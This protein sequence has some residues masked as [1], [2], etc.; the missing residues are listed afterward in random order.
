M[1]KAEILTAL[2]GKLGSKAKFIGVYTLHSIITLL[3]TGVISKSPIVFILLASAEGNNM[4]HWIAVYINPT[5][6]L[7]GFFDSYNEN[8]YFYSPNLCQLLRRFSK[9]GY[10]SN[11]FQLQG[12][13]SYVCGAYVIQFVSLASKYGVKHAFQYFM[14]VFKRGHRNYNDR[15]I[16]SLAFKQFRMPQCAQTFCFDINDRDCQRTI[17]RLTG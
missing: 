5:S 9:Y 17:C 13:Q 8:P 16:T 12:M 7:A 3:K 4:G 14:K 1:N 11:A 15:L 6:L 10:Y 2:S